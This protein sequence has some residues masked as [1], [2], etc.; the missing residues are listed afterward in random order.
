VVCLEA[1]A[2]STGIA[3]LLSNSMARNIKI[4]EQTMRKVEEG[5]FHVRAAPLGRDEVGMLSVRFNYMVTRINELIVVAYEERMAKQRAEFQTLLARI[6]PHFLYNT[7]GTIR[8]YSRMRRQ[9]D[10]EMMVSSLID[11]LKASLRRSGEFQPLG[12]ELDD[13]ASYI[14]LQKIGYGDAFEV[15]YRVDEPLRS[16]YVPFFTL[17]PLVENAILHGLEISKGGGSI[18][19]EASREAGELV[20]VVA[21]NGVGMD[22][23]TM[24]AILRDGGRGSTTQGLNSIGVRSIHERIRL[25]YGGRYGLEYDSAPGQG[26][27]AIVRLPYITDAEEVRR[28]AAG[29]DR[30]G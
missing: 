24:D 19:I 29:D 23:G 28:Y 27:Q 25:Y 4:L 6:N 26:T 7:L 10:I 16:C 9:P 21:D 15:V 3:V 18:V 20:V 2:I 8:W 14:H 5:D 12:Q 1:I 30:G 11:L 17:Q 13:L 22:A